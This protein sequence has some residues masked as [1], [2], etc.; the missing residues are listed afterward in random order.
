MNPNRT[1][2]FNKPFTF[3]LSNHAKYEI[4][5]ICTKYKNLKIRNHDARMKVVLKGLVS[6]G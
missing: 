6:K 2:P 5:P 1:K 3:I 4:V